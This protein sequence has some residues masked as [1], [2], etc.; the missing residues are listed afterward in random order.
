MLGGAEIRDLI[1]AGEI[2]ID[3]TPA[4]LEQLGVSVDLT[5]SEVFWRSGIPMYQ[6]V[7][8]T[9]DLSVADPYEYMEMT[10]AA[11]IILQPKDF[12]VAETAEGISLPLDIV[13]WIEGKSGRARQGLGIHLTAPKIDPGWGL[14]QPK[15]ITLEIVNH[16]HHKVKLKAGVPIA[17]LMF[18]KLAEAAVPYAGRHGDVGSR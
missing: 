9:V 12:V 18:H 1:N 11:E 7:D 10:T 16:L 17:Q 3:P 15:P 2:V 6:G 5:L 8:V 13:G 14:G 4:N